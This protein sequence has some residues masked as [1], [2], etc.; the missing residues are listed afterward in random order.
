MAATF[1]TMVFSVGKVKAAK[2]GAELLRAIK[3]YFSEDPEDEEEVL[4]I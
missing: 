4:N 1:L 2:Y 3:S